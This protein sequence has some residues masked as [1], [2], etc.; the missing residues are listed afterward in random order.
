MAID[1][2][3]SPVARGRKQG[4][5]SASIRP[6]LVSGGGAVRVDIEALHTVAAGRVPFGSTPAPVG[7]S[8]DP[9]RLRC[10]AGFPVCILSRSHRTTGAKRKAAGS[11]YQRLVSGLVHGAPPKGGAPCTHQDPDVHAPMVHL[12][13]LD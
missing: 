7:L 11:V 6:F 2:A 9:P 4:S 13:H 8:Q 12:V 10:G 1:G 3:G 5:V